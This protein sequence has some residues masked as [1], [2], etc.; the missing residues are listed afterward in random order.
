MQDSGQDRVWITG[1][2]SGIGRATALRFAAGGAT[3]LASSRGAEALRTLQEEAAARGL[4]GRILC[5]SLDVTDRQAVARTF[6]AIEAAEG[7]IRRAILNAGTYRPVQGRQFDADA[8]DLQFRLNVGGVVNC[9]DALVPAM[10]DRGGGQIAITGSLSGYRGLPQ[11]SAYGATKAA[12]MRI[13]ESLHAELRPAGIDVR[14][15]SPGFVRTPLTDRNDFP[16]PFLIPAETAAER[17]HRGLVHGRRFEIA[18]PR[19][20][21]ALV[22]AGSMLPYGVY[23]RLM[24]RIAR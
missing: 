2:S 17:I 4:Q 5:H 3:V 16:M 9:L 23:F 24:R 22:R 10:R 12:L 20:F 1:A 13:A 7:P 21:A 8:F 14:L 6:A 18:F 19:R 11:A 15:I